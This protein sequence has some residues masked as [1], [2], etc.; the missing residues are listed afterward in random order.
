MK[1]VLIF[2]FSATL[3]GFALGAS[4]QT[5][6]AVEFTSILFASGLV[7]WTVKQYSRRPLALTAVKPI[8]LPVRLSLG[9]LPA[10]NS[11]QQLAA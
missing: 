9:R 8:R 10:P 3:S 4:G 1:T 11:V 5:I 7:A 6:G 2:L